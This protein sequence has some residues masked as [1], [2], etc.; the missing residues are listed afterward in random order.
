MRTLYMKVLSLNDHVKK[1]RG[2]LIIYIQVLHN[3][4]KTKKNIN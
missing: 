3:I 1:V 4:I 2:Q